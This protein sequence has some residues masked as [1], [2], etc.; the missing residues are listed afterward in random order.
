MA[1][2][3]LQPKVLMKQPE[4]NKKSQKREQIPHLVPEVRIFR[5]MK[6]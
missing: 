6:P 2:F 5:E 4:R 1:K 3:S